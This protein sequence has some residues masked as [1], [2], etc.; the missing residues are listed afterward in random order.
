M[1]QD[2]RVAQI[3]FLA[4]FVQNRRNH[5]A[6][7]AIIAHFGQSYVHSIGQTFYILDAKKPVF[8]VQVAY[9]LKAK[10]TSSRFP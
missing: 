9:P 4:F 8:H 2:I 10:S 3:Y 5:T 7:S 6:A 1:V